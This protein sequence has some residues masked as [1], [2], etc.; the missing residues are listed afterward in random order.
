M[1]K[2]NSVHLMIGGK[3]NQLKNKYKPETMIVK[4]I[5]KPIITYPHEYYIE[6]ISN[7]IKELKKR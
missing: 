6:L 2:L 4:D 7:I 3:M 1:N 5:S